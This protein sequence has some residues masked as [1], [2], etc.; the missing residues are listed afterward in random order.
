MWSAVTSPSSTGRGTII[1]SVDGE[2]ASLQR[3]T[4]RPSFAMEGT[5]RYLF[6]SLMHL[7]TFLDGRVFDEDRST[8]TEFESRLIRL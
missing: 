6:T 2:R 3:T 8:P 5:L 4:I 7:V 1:K